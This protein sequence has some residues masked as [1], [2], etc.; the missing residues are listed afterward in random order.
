MSLLQVLLGDIQ[1]GGLC[2]GNNKW[3]WEFSAMAY[4]KF[5]CYLPP[6]YHSLGSNRTSVVNAIKLPN[7]LLGS[8]CYKSLMQILKGG[9]VFDGMRKAPVLPTVGFLCSSGGGSSSHGL[10]IGHLR[11]MSPTY[12]RHFWFLSGQ[13]SWKNWVTCLTLSWAVPVWVAL[14]HRISRYISQKLYSISHVK[15]HV[16]SDNTVFFCPVFI[17]MRW[18]FFTKNQNIYKE[19]AAGTKLPHVSIKYNYFKLSPLLLLL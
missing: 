1:W 2:M 19:R 9:V 12:R 13:E 3:S 17:Q 7:I 6:C 14:P 11:L 8:R 18:I 4:E 5:S 10:S 15:F 16:C